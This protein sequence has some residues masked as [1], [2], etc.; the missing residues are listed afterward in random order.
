[1][2]AV[3]TVAVAGPNLVVSRVIGFEHD[4]LAVGRK[5]GARVAV[6]LRALTRQGMAEIGRPSDGQ[7]NKRCS[8]PPVAGI[9]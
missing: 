7:E 2:S 8:V 3:Q 1:M 6:V 5:L 4:F 9:M